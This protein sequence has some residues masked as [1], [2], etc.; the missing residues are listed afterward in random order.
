MN[1]LITV[2]GCGGAHVAHENEVSSCSLFRDAPQ[3][4]SLTFMRTRKLQSVIVWFSLSRSYERRTGLITILNPVC[5]ALSPFYSKSHLNARKRRVGK[6][7]LGY[8][9]TTR[10]HDTLKAGFPLTSHHTDEIKDSFFC[11]SKTCFNQIVMCFFF[12]LI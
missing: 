5:R 9:Q 3:Q 10:C 12:R 2:L 7:E 8:E 1:I 11:I 6:R 4:R